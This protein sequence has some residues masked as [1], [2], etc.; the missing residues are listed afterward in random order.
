[1]RAK[2]VDLAQTYQY[3]DQNQD[4]TARMLVML[5]EQIKELIEENS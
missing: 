5:S 4:E 1:M 3:N 2:N